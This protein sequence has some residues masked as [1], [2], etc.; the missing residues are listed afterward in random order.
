[1][2][3][4]ANRYSDLDNIRTGFTVCAY[5][6]L[7]V[8]PL[9]VIPRD[10]KDYCVL[11][12]LSVSAAISGFVSI[13]YMLILGNLHSMTTEEIRKIRDRVRIEKYYPGT[14]L[15]NL[16][17][18]QLPEAEEEPSDVIEKKRNEAFLYVKKVVAVGAVCSLAA[19]SI[20]YYYAYPYLIGSE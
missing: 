12:I 11:S 7:V 15:P 2:G 5:G 19:L 18:S 16:P 4:N 6:L 10:H 9:I 1:M 17:L 3:I 20:T 8:T 14:Q 13:F